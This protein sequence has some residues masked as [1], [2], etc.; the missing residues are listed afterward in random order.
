MGGRCGNDDGDRPGRI[1]HRPRG[2]APARRDQQARDRRR[3]DPGACACGQRGPGHLAPDGRLPYPMRLAGFGLRR[4]KAPNPGRSLAG[5]VEAAGQQVTGF[6]PGDEVYGTCEGSFAPYARAR[7]G[8]LAPKPANLSLRRPGRPRLR[9][10][11]A[12]GRAGP[13]KVQAG[14]KVLSSARPEAS[15]RSPCRSPRPS[16]PK[17]PAWPARPRPTWSAPSAP[18]TSPTTPGRTSPTAS[19]ATTSSS[20]SAGPTGSPICAGPHP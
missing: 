17:S 1:R 13:G 2:R 12:A 6:E 8:R 14:Q 9:A 16:A 20:T 18:A 19:T 15:A 3:R 7:A 11:R 4:P 10:H 5:T